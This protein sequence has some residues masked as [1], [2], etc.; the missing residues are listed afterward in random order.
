MQQS[1][2][3][4]NTPIQWLGRKLT[5]SN[6]QL[7]DEKAR[8][9]M[10]GLVGLWRDILEIEDDRIF[11]IRKNSKKGT[12]QPLDNDLTVNRQQPADRRT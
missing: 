6:V 1:D 5:L 8:E 12:G 11:P 3:C 10:G 9:L 7:Q 2:T 4:G